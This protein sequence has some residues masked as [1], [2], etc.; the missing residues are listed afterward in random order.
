ME[1]RFDTR[2]ETNVQLGCRLPALPQRGALVD[3]SHYGCRMAVG[4]AN[5]ELGTTALI[6]LPGAPAFKGTV[7]WTNGTQVG[8]RFHR[9]LPGP[10]AVAFGLEQPKAKPAP[11]VVQ[12]Y[13]AQGLLSHWVRRLFG[14]G[15]SRA[16]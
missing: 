7:V 4:T 12:E 6:D 16:A 10:P 11:E 8:I 2:I 15:R 9:R 5:A 14:A 3:V 13:Q 1:R